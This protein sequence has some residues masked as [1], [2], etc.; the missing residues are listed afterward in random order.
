MISSARGGEGGTGKVAAGIAVS[1]AGANE[2][3]D[4]AGVG[5]KK[6]QWRPQG[7]TT[8]RRYRIVTDEGVD[9]GKA[10]STLKP[11]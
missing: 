7:G 3:P 9:E 10:E 4:A 2:V 6:E 1:A 11:V 5:V 8:G